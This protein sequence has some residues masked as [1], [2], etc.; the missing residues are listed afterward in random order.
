MVRIRV[1]LRILKIFFYMESENVTGN[2]FC[3]P[4]NLRVTLIEPAR[5][6]IT[7]VVNNRCCFGVC[8]CVYGNKYLSL[9]LPY[10]RFQQLCMLF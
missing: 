4:L 7:V 6:N 5:R 2:K 8:V 10:P 3:F 9:S 1:L